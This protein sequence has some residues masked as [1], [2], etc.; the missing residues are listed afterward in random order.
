SATQRRARVTFA[1]HRQ[2]GTAAILFQRYLGDRAVGD[3]FAVGREIAAQARMAAATN[4]SDPVDQYRRIRA[5]RLTETLAQGSSRCLA[6]CLEWIDRP[7]S[8]RADAQSVARHIA[9]HP[10]HD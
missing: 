8:A 3:H 4:R 1:E 6:E 10:G 5:R 9:N 7:G 2:A